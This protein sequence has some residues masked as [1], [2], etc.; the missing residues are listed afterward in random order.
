MTRNRGVAGARGSG[1]SG[2]R[3]AARFGSGGTAGGR[4]RGRFDSSPRPS[5][6]TPRAGDPARSRARPPGRRGGAGQGSGGA[7]K[8]TRA[9]EPG[10]LT[11]RAAV[12]AVVLLG[13]LLAYAYPIRVYLAQQAQ[14]SSIEA[15]QDVQRRKISK[16]AEE[17]E[18]WNYPEFVK[19]QV[20]SRLMWT[21]EGETPYRVVGGGAADEPT[22]ADQS[23]QQPA[24]PRPWYGK[25]WQS[26]AGADRR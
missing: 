21:E 16:L 9:P 15:Q 14:I 20:R 10:G 6:Y 3:A 24:R 26:I 8:R 18:K 23:S 1:P 22:A 25:L 4:A 19:S 13:L 11:G 5:E 2:A 12:L 7:V 17:R